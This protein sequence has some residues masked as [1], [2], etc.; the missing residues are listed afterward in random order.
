MDFYFI[1]VFNETS[2]AISSRLGRKSAYIWNE[3]KFLT[4]FAVQVYT[5]R[6]AALL[7]KGI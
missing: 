6:H 2:K 5:S 7:L 4:D 3:I 1:V